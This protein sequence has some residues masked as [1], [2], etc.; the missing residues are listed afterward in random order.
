LLTRG[1][2]IIPLAE[3]FL[4]QLSRKYKLPQTVLSEKSKSYLLSHTWPGNTREL[5]HALER[6]LVMSEKGSQLEL[7]SVSTELKQTAS[8]VEKDWL[9]TSFS[10]PSEGFDLEKEILRLIELAIGQAKGNV[11]EAARILGVPRDYI[12]YR[13]PPKGD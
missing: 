3:H 13:L 5:I 8:L 1:K 6:A 4:F 12:R 7:T 2:D 9:N 11:S 10:F